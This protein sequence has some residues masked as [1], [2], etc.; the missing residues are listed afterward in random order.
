M[1][2]VLEQSLGKRGFFQRHWRGEYSFPRSFWLHTILLSWFAPIAT[3][4][5]LSS[6]PW[7]IPGRAASVAFVA[8]FVIFYPLFLWGMF[9]TGRAGRSYREK[10]G[11]KIWVTTATLAMT[12]LFMDSLFFYLARSAIVMEHARMVFTGRYG[13]PAS[14]SRTRNGAGLLLSGELREGSAEA[15]ALAIRNSPNISSVVLDSKGGLFQEATLLAT[16][17]SQRHLDTYVEGECSSACTLAFLAG[18]RRCIAEDARIGFHA[19][20]YRGDLTR[21]TSRNAADYERNLYLKAG[22]PATFINTIMETPNLRVWYPSHRELQ[23]AGV[24]SADCP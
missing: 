12:L 8:I 21:G 1:T 15:F 22:L 16:N 2:V 11:R 6:N 17:I 20:T 14:I 9:G 23:E 19:V 5:L 7:H 13:P 18:T 3:L 10:G 4:S 24:T